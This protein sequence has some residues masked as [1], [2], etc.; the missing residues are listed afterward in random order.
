[1]TERSGF[2][3]LT[4]GCTAVRRRAVLTSIALA[5]SLAGLLVLVLSLLPAGVREGRGS[6]VPLGLAFLLWAGLTAAAWLAR[7]TWLMVRPDAVA[8]EVDR[9]AGLGDG[10]V[11]VALELERRR[12]GPGAG[13][14][15]LHRVRVSTALSRLDLAGMLPRTGPRWSRRARR[16]AWMG[17][18]T[19]LTVA[20]V[21]WAR[22]QPTLSAAAALGAPWRTAFPPPLPALDVRGPGGV[23]R[24]QPVTI[25]ISAVG[26]DRVTLVWRAAGQVIGRRELPVSAGGDA[27]GRTGPI[28]SPTRIW[29]ED[30]SGLASDTLL[31]RPRE[32]LLVQDLQV[33]VEYPAYLG[34]SSEAHRGQIPPLVVPEGATIRLTG[35]SNLPID[36]GALSWRPADAGPVE[37]G[38]TVPLD[39]SGTRFAAS[40][41]PRRTGTW[42]WELVAAASAGE[43]ITPGPI[44]VL[45]VPD[46]EP[47]IQ[48]LYP[49][50]DTTLGFERVMPLVVDVEDDIGLRQAYV[51]SWRSGL[52][53]VR[54]ER[55]E[56]LSPAPAGAQ[57]SVFRHLLDRKSEEFLPGDTLFYQIEAFDGRPS[58]GPTLSDVF[59][60]RVP[61]FTEMRDQRAEDTEALSDAAETLEDAL[62]ALTEAA[63]DAARL[64][65]AEGEDSEDA[66]FEATEEARSVL[67]DAERAGEQLES[68]EE[69]LQALRDELDESS[70]SDP[71]LE[72]QL[73]RLAERYEELA[74][75]GLAD[76]I[77][78][79][80]EAL[81]D[82]DPEAVRAALEDLARDSEELREQLDQTLGLLEQAALEQAMQSAQAN[83]DELAEAQRDLAQETDAASFQEEQQS[84]A[85]RTEQLAERLAELEENLAAAD[86]QTAA[87]SAAAAGERTEEALDNMAAAQS[88]A[89]QS[90]AA[91]GEQGEVSQGQKS[92]AEQAAEALEQAASAL[93]SAQQDMNGESGEAAAQTLGRARSEALALAEE[94][95]RLADATRGED[96]A[97][98]EAW[99]AEQGAVRQGL[100]NLLE[101]LSDA[102]NEAAMLDQRTGAAAGQ[103]AE[104]MDRLLQRLAEDGARRLPSRAEAESI[105]ESLN[106]LT[107]HLMASEQAAQAAQQQSAGQDAAQQMSQLAQ[108][109]QAV[110]QETSS[111]LMPGP[112]PAGQER[113]QEEIAR[114]QEEIAEELGQL[115]DPEDDLLGR[116][117]ELAAEAA[118]LARDLELQG[119]TQETLERQRQLFQR[120]LD[121]G[122]SLED[123]DLDPEQRESEA[124]TAGPRAPPEIDPDLIRGR[125]FPLPSEA[126]LRDLPIFYRAMIFEYFDRLNRSGTGVAGAA[127]RDP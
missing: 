107:Q 95:G 70:L 39:L 40:W 116:P 29:A 76:R 50:P 22:P 7:R 83:A 42:V 23:P 87:D 17:G 113:R 8:E 20:A 10:D 47:R 120:M 97:E 81:R 93:G 45:V 118:E 69:D 21:A 65:D 43:P 1:M 100:E 126:L 98:P 59:L 108:Q 89:A 56:S 91:Q 124:A 4:A 94:E 114:R 115:E 75:Q 99:R 92:A 25:E 73:R 62:E 79:L 96:T 38:R 28:E 61:T 26:R 60:L 34:R 51:R 121:A 6:L 53:E 110:T 105:Q 5:I 31:I 78:E 48:L 64:T 24:G 85:E 125:R 19:L 123:E 112:K 67:D 111:L 74:E 35:E 63:A 80:A 9:G 72:E 109:Q 11:R 90:E 82:L 54:A 71:A 86:R 14:A 18:L 37:T 41:V 127:R 16:S 106:E 12:D 13:L 122:R 15:A 32:P 30:A 55:R 104:Q 77:A 57:R 27:A 117:E 36:A 2:D 119:P 44:H 46:L 3:R 58:R 66:R 103:A 88:E 52:G 49:A 102:G 84:L 68:L 101:R 33:V